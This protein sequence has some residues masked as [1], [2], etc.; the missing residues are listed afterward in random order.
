MDIETFGAWISN[1]RIENKTVIASYQG[2]REITER[3]DL[4]C[5]TLGGDRFLVRAKS[6]R[7]LRAGLKKLSR[8]RPEK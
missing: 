4:H 3:T 6:I 8:K 7:A 5:T 1:V 2:C